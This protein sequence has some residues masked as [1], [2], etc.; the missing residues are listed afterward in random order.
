MRDTG[1]SRYRGWYVDQ[2]SPAQQRLL[3][4]ATA[5]MPYAEVNAACTAYIR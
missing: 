3:S 4:A 1:L 5:M 2:L